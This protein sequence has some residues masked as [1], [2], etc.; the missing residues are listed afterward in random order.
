M[1]EVNEE[2][3]EYATD[4]KGDEKDTAAEVPESTTATGERSQKDQNERTGDVHIPDFNLPEKEDKLWF[5]LTFYKDGGWSYQKRA[6]DNS[7]VEWEIPIMDSMK[8]ER[9]LMVYDN[10]CVNVVTPYDVIKPRG[11]RGRKFRTREKIYRNG[12]N[13]NAKLVE[14]FCAKSNDLVIFDS[15][16]ANGTRWVK[17]H[18]VSA[19]SVHTSL[20]LE[21]N[22]LV[23]KKRFGATLQAVSL[24]PLDC[25]HLISS[26]VLKDTQTSGYLG[27]KSTERNYQKTFKTLKQLIEEYRKIWKN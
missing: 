18:N 7:E 24:L 10:G 21:G 27:V 17:A 23:N 4:G 5:H 2:E 13:T 22:V 1:E 15:F 8:K 25:Y 6:V 11:A 12:W 14:V 26:L 19:I 3:A 16:D 9:M 20:H